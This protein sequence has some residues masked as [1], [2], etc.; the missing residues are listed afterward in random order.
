MLRRTS[1]YHGRPRAT[2]A[3]ACSR[4][5]SA[6]PWPCRPRPPMRTR[7]GACARSRTSCRPSP[8]APAP[9]GAIEQRGQPAHRHRRRRRSRPTRAPRTIFQGNVALNRGDQFL[10]HR[11][12]DLQRRNRQRYV[13]EGNV[14]YQDSGMRV[15]A[16]RAEG[17][18]KDD[19][20]TIEDVRYQLTERRGN[21]GADAHR[22]PGRP[23]H[24]APLDLFHL[25]TLG[26]LR[27]NCARGVSMSTTAE[28]FGV[29]RNATL[30][31]GKVPVHVHAMVHVPGRRPPPHR[32][33]LS[34]AL[35]SAVATASTTSS[36]STSTWRRTTTPR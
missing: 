12:A 31:L 15:I 34:A 1:P 20:H 22:A 23:G 2:I 24:A 25:L 10:Q 19:T 35:A 14:R 3:S 18:Q 7:T 32:P 21:G 29:A 30:R 4:C 8:S 27:G 28:G 6:S 17:N 36:R 9:T 5:R 33:A 13:A 11:Q 16:E 26:A